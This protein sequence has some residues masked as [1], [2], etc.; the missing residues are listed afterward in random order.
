[1]Q[2]V[3]GLVQKGAKAVEDLNLL[4]LLQS[5][6]Q[7]ELSSDP[8][9]KSRSISLGDFVLEWDSPQT[10]DVFLRR[11]MECGEE[12]AVSAKLAPLSDTPGREKLMY[13]RDVMMKICVKKPGLSSILQFD[14]EV[15]ENDGLGSGFEIS[16][17]YLFPSPA[18]IGPNVYRG[19]PSYYLGIDTHPELDKYLAAKGIGEELTNFLLHHLHKKEQD[20]YVNWL[21]KLESFVA[22]EAKPEW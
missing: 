21:Q 7:H 18:R 10:Q 5:E 3:R 8:F 11:K 15:W 9:P 1:M 17:I 22:K 12:V 2:K 14:C 20:Q 4:K 13:P 19:R 6:I 16:E